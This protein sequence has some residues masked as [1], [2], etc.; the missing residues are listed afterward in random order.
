MDQVISRLKELIAVV[1]KLGIKPSVNDSFIF[2]IRSTADMDQVIS[3]L[4][5]LVAVADIVKNA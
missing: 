2:L 5:E 1:E 3:R 4:K